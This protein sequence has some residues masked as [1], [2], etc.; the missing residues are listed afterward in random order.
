MSIARR[1]ET[2]LGTERRCTRCK[3]Y[4]PEDREFFYTS[5]RINRATV[6]IQQPCKACFDEMKRVSR[7]KNKSKLSLVPGN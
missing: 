2:E 7:K 4:W 5:K 1:I 6:D 3:E